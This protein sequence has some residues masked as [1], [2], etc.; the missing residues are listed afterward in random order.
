MTTVII[1]TEAGET[2]E[3]ILINHVHIE[4]EHAN[5]YIH[6]VLDLAIKE[7]IKIDRSRRAAAE[8][9]LDHILK[10]VDPKNREEKKGS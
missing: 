6:T 4:D 8:K 2:I 7:G 5:D 10:A 9:L 1:K 3:T